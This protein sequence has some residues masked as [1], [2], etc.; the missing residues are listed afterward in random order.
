M[1][2]IQEPDDLAEPALRRRAVAAARGDVP[3]DV[4]IAGGTLVDMTTGE[5]RAADVGIVGPLIASVH[6]RGKRDDAAE[7][8]DAL[9][10]FISPGLIDTHMHV[11]SSMVTPAV[12]ARSGS[13]AGRH[14]DRLGPA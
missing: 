2:D 11:E 9:G 6:A 3:F 5:L 7:A 13:A 8:I 10:A 1:K 4:L 14:D 12:Y